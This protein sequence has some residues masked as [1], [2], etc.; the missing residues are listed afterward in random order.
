MDSGVSR[1]ASVAWRCILCVRPD[2]YARGCHCWDLASS[3][4]GF[5]LRLSSGSDLVLS[6]SCVFFR[7]A[8]G[9][10]RGDVLNE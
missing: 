7:A 2:V 10:N 3:S 5:L 1:H 8:S 4:G 9:A 6:F